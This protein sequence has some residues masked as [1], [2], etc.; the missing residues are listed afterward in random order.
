MIRALGWSSKP[1]R[2]VELPEPG[3]DPG[4]FDP[5]EEPGQPLPDEVASPEP[6]PAGRA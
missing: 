2:T 4:F 3:G 6:V 5:P 1:L